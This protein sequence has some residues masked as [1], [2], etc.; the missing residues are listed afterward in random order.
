MR[1]TAGFTIIELVAV[2]VILGI[3]AAVALPRY[4]DLSS[5]ALTA[6]CNAWKGSIE[7]GAA[8]NYAS[9]AA[10]N[11]MGSSGGPVQMNTC[12]TG[13]VGSTAK[14]IG[15][16]VSGGLPASA[17][18]F[19]SVTSGSVPNVNGQT[20]S[21][22]IHYNAGGGSCSTTVNVIAVNS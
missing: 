3:L 1:R 11:A 2:I 16:I 19:V 20:G 17:T 9:R 21:C 12:G 7:G 18:T 13:Q 5:S 8:I 4:L 22:V 15:A 14:T 10:G 6:S